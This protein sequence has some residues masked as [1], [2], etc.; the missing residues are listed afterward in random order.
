MVD[1]RK[2]EIASSG[3]YSPD[4][5]GR[6]VRPPVSRLLASVNVVDVEKRQVILEGYVYKCSSGTLTSR[7]QKRYFVLRES[8]LEYFGTESAAKSVGAPSVRFPVKKIKSV[9]ARGGKEFDLHIGGNQRRYQLKTISSQQSAAWV[10]AIDTVI[11]QYASTREGAG[12]GSVDSIVSSESSSARFGGSSSMAASE[13]NNLTATTSEEGAY[14]VYVQDTLLE[15]QQELYISGEEIDALFS[16]WFSFLTSSSSEIKAGRMI[17]AASR[18]VSDLWAVLGGLTR[19]ED[20]SFEEARVSIEK[21]LSEI[22]PNTYNQIVGEYILRLCQKVR[23]WLLGPPTSPDDVPVLIEWVA[24]LQLQLDELLAS[25]QRDEAGALSPTHSDRGTILARPEKWRKSIKLLLRRLGADWEVLLIEYLN[26]SMRPESTWD[27]PID[28][29]SVLPSCIIGMPKQ[30]GP[31]LMTPWTFEFLTVIS[32]KCLSRSTKGTPWSVAYPTSVSLLTAHCAN[33]MIAALNSAWRELKVRATG[34]AK[35]KG[36]KMGKVLNRM[37][38]QRGVAGRRVMALDNMLAFGNECTLISVFCQHAS[39]QPEM[40]AASP[41][42]GSCLEALSGAFANTSQQVAKS[43]VSIHFVGKEKIVLNHA[44][45]PKVLAVRLK[46]PIAES[47][48]VAQQFIDSLPKMGTH[49]LLRYLLVGQ[50]MVAVANSYVESVVLHR[51]KISKFSRLAAVVAEDEALFFSMFRDLGRPSTEINAAIDPISHIRSVLHESN[52]GIALVQHCIEI[53]R[54]FSS[55]EQAVQVIK[56]LL[57]I[58]GISKTDKRDILFSV[59]ACVQRNLESPS[60][61]IDQD[62]S[63][64]SSQQEQDSCSE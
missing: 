52:G 50:V 19:G 7:W 16:E 30:Q 28:G 2:R 13:R 41:V 24:R 4:Q 8:E 12:G 56:A 54:T 42:F 60:P 18:S 49:E 29:K 20:L 33:A 59:S 63:R 45:D 3:Q 57:D 17:D 36:G 10:S 43:I 39:I 58:K 46:V 44:F 11:S 9:Q 14:V 32:E 5:A 25:S 48:E 64:I 23:V 22:G 21:K 31:I 37:K 6:D 62:A 15:H 35:G 53:T 38:Q 51:P 55:F 47:L 61:A 1:Q 26:N 27:D 40:R 34:Y